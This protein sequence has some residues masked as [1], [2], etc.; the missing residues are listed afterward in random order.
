M[1][2][3]LYKES[4]LIPGHFSLALWLSRGYFPFVLGY[5]AASRA[6]RLSGDGFL[7]DVVAQVH[8]ERVR[9]SEV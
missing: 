8:Q 4:T 6:G 3:L 2:L 9:V 7:T 5:L 1:G